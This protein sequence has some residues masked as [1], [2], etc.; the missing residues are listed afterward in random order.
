M[1]NELASAAEGQITKAKYTGETK[2]RNFET[3]FALHKAQHQILEDL[4]DHGFQGMDEDNKVQ[5]LTNGI[6]TDAMNVIKANILASPLLKGNLMDA[7][8]SSKYSSP[9]DALQR[10]LWTSAT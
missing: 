9:Q 1:V 6:K 4:K 3:Y 5:H 2:L 8:R 10:I 7:S